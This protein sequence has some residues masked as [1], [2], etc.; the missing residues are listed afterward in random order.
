MKTVKIGLLGLGTVGSGVFKILQTQA[1]KI[2]RIAGC[3]LQAT[4]ALVR[5]PGKHQDLAQKVELVT[6]PEQILQDPGI[7]IVA[8]LMGGLHPAAEYLQQAIAAGK[9]V[10]TANKDLLATAGLPLIKLAQDKGVSLRYEASVA[11]AIPIL[12]VLSQNFA[13]D[14]I[15]EITG[16]VNGTTNYIL[17]QMSEQGADFEQALK[18]AQDLGFAEADPT[19]DV[20]GKDAA[21]KMIILTRFAFGTDLQLR[22]FHYDGIQAVRT[23]DVQAAKTWGYVIKLIGL[24]RQVGSG[25]FVEVAPCLVKKDS[26]LGQIRNADNGLAVHSWA[27]GTSFFAGPGAGS[28]PTANSVVSDLIAEA[29]G[30]AGGHS[31]NRY[32]RQLGKADL[33][34]V[35]D[36]YYLLIKSHDAAV[37]K[38][39]LRG[40]QLDLQKMQPAQDG[41]AVLTKKASRQQIFNLEAE[42]QAEGLKIMTADKVLE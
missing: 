19:N 9:N 13:G 26:R 6:D 41:L 37:V 30:Q 16:I 5:N 3:R 2:A 21:Y 29:S 32:R 38:R 15:Q 20:S 10:V 17:T 40:Q 34:K 8:E 35:F 25:L 39:L 18:K 27:V 31:F 1:D 12:N 7:S 42:A 4:K 36:P 11:G 33:A 28:L 23:A 24:S 22:D 14:Q